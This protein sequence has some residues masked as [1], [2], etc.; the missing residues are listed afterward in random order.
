MR[1]GPF[2]YNP[3][4]VTANA[5]PLPGGASLHG[6][7]GLFFKYPLD[8][9]LEAND[10]SP[11]IHYSLIPMDHL[12]VF[13]DQCVKMAWFWYVNRKAIQTKGISATFDCIASCH[14]HNRHFFIRMLQPSKLLNNPY[15]LVY[16]HYASPGKN[17]S[18]LTAEIDFKEPIYWLRQYLNIPEGSKWDLPTK[19]DRKCLDFYKVKMPPITQRH[20]P[21]LINEPI[22]CEYANYLLRHPE[23][24]VKPMLLPSFYNS[25]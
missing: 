25:F 23:E 18:K 11:M 12:S 1:V 24:F 6:K 13:L 20:L 16:E 9:F 10:P 4:G 14:S 7:Q 21:L 22:L 5:G 17:N 3:P 19:Y 8:D 2:S 15:Q